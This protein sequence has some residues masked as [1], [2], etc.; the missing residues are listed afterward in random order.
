MTETA[1][2]PAVRYEKDADNIVNLV[3]DDPD[4][5]ANTMNETFEAGFVAALE[6]LESE[7]AAGTVTGV[8]ISS[9]KSTFFA[10]GNL[11][12]L[13]AIGPYDAREIY[14][15]SMQ[16]K[17][18]LR[19]VETCGNQLIASAPPPVEEPAALDVRSIE[20]RHRRILRRPVAASLLS[21]VVHTRC[22]TLLR[23]GLGGA[24]PGG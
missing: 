16:I 24:A 18:L 2:A 4:A 17:A 9:A 12:R 23:A 11:K 22:T 5:S 21:E 14:D 1:T 19:R 7:I 15:A 10:G 13:L 8:V 20:S 6:R 3:M